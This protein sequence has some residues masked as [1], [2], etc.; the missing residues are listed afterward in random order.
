MY[1]AFIARERLRTQG[2]RG[3]K[4][5]SFATRGAESN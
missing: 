5:W 3:A 1:S 4:G 2:G